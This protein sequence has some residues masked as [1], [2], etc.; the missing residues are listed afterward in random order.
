VNKTRLLVAV[1][2]DEEAVRIA[3]R[4]LLGSASFRVETFSSGPEFLESL[5]EHQPD[6]LVLDLFPPHINGFAV[7]ARLAEMGTRLPTVVTSGHDSDED[8]ERAL[9]GGAA[10]YLSKPVDDQ[11]LL[12]AITRAVNQTT[13]EPETMTV[14]PNRLFATT[15]SKH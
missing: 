7:Q 9:N 3:L 2:D 4:R 12:D 14:R 6:C 11:A 15:V 1:V 10:A 5:N 13:A 8:R